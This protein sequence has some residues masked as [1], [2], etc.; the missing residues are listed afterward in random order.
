MF[1]VGSP[2][3]SRVTESE[4]SALRRCLIFSY[5]AGIVGKKKKKKE[6]KR[7]SG[8]ELRR[9]DTRLNF[10]F[11]R[12]VFRRFFFIVSRGNS[13]RLLLRR[14]RGVVDYERR[15]VRILFKH[16]KLPRSLSATLSRREGTVRAVYFI[17]FNAAPPTVCIF[18]LDINP[19]VAVIV[20]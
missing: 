16:F 4:P 20:K 12:P 7:K 18:L 9:Q 2:G 3:T 15:R 17:L 13:S 19:S 6:K 10:I 11:L 14:L 5:A 1:L 8:G